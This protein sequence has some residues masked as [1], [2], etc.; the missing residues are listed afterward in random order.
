MAALGISPKS[1][2]SADLRRDIGTLV[3]FAAIQGNFDAWRKSGVV[4]SVRILGRTMDPVMNVRSC[5]G[6][7]GVWNKFRKFLIQAANLRWA[8]AALSLQTSVRTGPRERMKSHSALIS[9]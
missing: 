3:K 1:G 2:L 5:M 9:N 8:V 4:D 7:Y 6:A